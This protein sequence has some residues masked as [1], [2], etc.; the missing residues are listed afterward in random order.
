MAVIIPR[1]G[2]YLYNNQFVPVTGHNVDLIM[3]GMPIGV[4]YTVPELLQI[5]DRQFFTFITGFVVKSH[6]S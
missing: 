2:F 3:P 6:L 1:P 4:Q 5:T